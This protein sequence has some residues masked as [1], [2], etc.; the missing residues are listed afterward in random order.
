MADSLED[1]LVKLVG[2]TIVSLKRGDERV[3]PGGEG[4]IVV[5]DSMTEEAFVAWIVARY[6]QSAEYK[7]MPEEERRGHREYLTVHYNVARRWARKPLKF[8]E[9]QVEVLGE[10]RDALGEANVMSEA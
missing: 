1:E 3:M 8:E 7:K 5:T 6:C 9:R 4:N 2:Y 10:I